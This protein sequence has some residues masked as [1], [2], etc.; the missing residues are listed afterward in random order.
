MSQE[1]EK[2]VWRWVILIVALAFWATVG[3][4]AYASVTP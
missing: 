1:R 3:L 2:Q 4:F